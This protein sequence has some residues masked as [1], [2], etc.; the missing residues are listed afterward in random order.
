MRPKSFFGYAQPFFHY[1]LLTAKPPLPM[2]ISPA[3]DVTLMLPGEMGAIGS[4]QIRVGY[5]V[6]SGEL[7]QGRDSVGPAVLSSVTGTI[8]AIADFTGDYGRRY[9]A[10]SIKPS[11]MEE[12]ASYP[13]KAPDIETLVRVFATAPGGN[14]TPL[15]MPS[16]SSIHTIVILGGD[17]DLLVTSN[18]YALKS[19]TEA[20]NRGIAMLKQM[21][22]IERVVLTI[23]RESFQNFDGHST[24]EVIALP[25]RYPGSQPL[26]IFYQLFGRMLSQGQT[27][28]GAGVLFLRAENV[29]AM[30]TA[31]AGGRIPMDKIVTVIDKQGNSRMV[32]ARIGTP[33]GDILRVLRITINQHDRVILG[34]PM[35]GTAIYAESQPILPDTD[36]IMV[37]DHAAI[38]LSSD[39][40]CINCGECVHVC[41]ARIQTHMLV[42]YLEAG[43]YQDGADLYDLYSCVECG[44]CNLVCASRIPILQFVKLAKYELARLTI[45]EEAHE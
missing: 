14:S 3:S 4:D 44:L 18:L 20:L 33:L 42:R 2:P 23:P 30:G 43:Q 22:G 9:T 25:N 36:A 27:F 15:R 5:T 28:E 29:V 10:I 34:G 1:E 7:L 24:A 41:P 17:S 12:W 21:P 19:R 26:M 6:K 39:Y 37:Q 13:T 16:N 40:P 35:T 38:V 32:S 8:G 11:P 45:V 31:L